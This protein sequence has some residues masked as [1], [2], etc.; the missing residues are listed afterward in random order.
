MVVHDFPKLP[1]QHVIES[2]NTCWGKVGPVTEHTV[3]KFT[4]YNSPGDVRQPISMRFTSGE[5]TGQWIFCV[6]L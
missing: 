2:M 1:G 3:D 6:S 5:W 4:F